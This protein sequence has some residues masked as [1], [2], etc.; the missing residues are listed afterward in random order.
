METKKVFNSSHIF[1][2]ANK[3]VSNCHYK[4]T[5]AVTLAAFFSE[6][7]DFFLL[8][9]FFFLLVMLFAKRKENKPNVVVSFKHD[10]C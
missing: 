1:S 8:S 2:C 3:L 9:F 7:H 10:E 6:D 5:V 4:L